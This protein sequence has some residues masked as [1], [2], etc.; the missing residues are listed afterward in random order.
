MALLLRC[1]FHGARAGAGE[2]GREGA[3]N[4]PRQKEIVGLECQES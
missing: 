2:E 4:N 1:L 3:R